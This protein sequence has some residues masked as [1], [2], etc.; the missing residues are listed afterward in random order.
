[1]EGLFD[2]FRFIF[3]GSIEKGKMWRDYLTAPEFLPRDGSLWQDALDE[4]A[5]LLEPG[6]GA[7]AH[8][9]K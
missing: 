2:G 3:N 9:W 8:S 6:I 7:H 4:D 5:E 1:M